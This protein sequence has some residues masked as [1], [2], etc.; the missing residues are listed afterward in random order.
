VS[1]IALAH[2]QMA[3]TPFF[4]IEGLALPSIPLRLQRCPRLFELFSRA[5]RMRAN[6]IPLAG[7]NRNQMALGVELKFDPGLVEV[8]G[9]CDQSGKRDIRRAI[10][11]LVHQ[12]VIESGATIGGWNTPLWHPELSLHIEDSSNAVLKLANL[13]RRNFGS[14]GRGAQQYPATNNG[15]YLHDSHGFPRSQVLIPR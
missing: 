10:R 8:H 3:L 1:T 7:L 6:K 4:S 13:G 12:D 5:S 9:T 11:R 2:S 15:R 14:L